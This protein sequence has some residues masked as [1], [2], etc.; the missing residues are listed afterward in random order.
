[1]HYFSKI[2]ALLRDYYSALCVIGF[3]VLFDK[4]PAVAKK[5]LRAEC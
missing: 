4:Q 3:A 1:M 5:F 2:Q